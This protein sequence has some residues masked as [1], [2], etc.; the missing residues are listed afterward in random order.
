MTDPFP[1]RPVGRCRTGRGA[2]IH[3]A[4]RRARWWSAGP[5]HRVADDGFV[6]LE[7]LIA[8]CLIAVVMAGF[9]TFF[10]NSVASTSAQR[11]TQIATQIA[12]SG[13][14][15]IRALPASDLVS[16]MT[17]PASDFSSA[18]LPTPCSRGCRE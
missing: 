15:L 17:P 5:G 7:T 4:A 10:V 14:E 16:G 1:T 6:L 13:V 9:T 8:I 18:Q 11:A 3:R 2:G 12:N